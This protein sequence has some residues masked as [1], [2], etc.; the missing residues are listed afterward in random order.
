MKIVTPSGCEPTLS[1]ALTGRVWIDCTC[2][3]G[4]PLCS[5][6]VEA[7]H[8]YDIHAQCELAR[9]DVQESDLDPLARADAHI[10][11]CPLDGTQIYADAICGTC[12][13][14]QLHNRDRLTKRV[15]A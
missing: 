15:A 12:V 6:A 14:R 4:T 3:Y 1:T 8:L 13:A 9:V 2:G 11:R 7:W 10:S 5:A